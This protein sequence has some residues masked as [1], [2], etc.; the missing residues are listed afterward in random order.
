VSCVAE[1]TA[2]GVVDYQVEVSHLHLRVRL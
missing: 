2:A 1:H